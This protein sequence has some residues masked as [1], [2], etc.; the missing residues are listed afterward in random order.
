MRKLINQIVG[1]ENL[2]PNTD[3]LMFF[4][5]RCNPKLNGYW[6]VQRAKRIVAFEPV[7]YPLLLSMIGDEK[8]WQEFQ[9]MLEEFSMNKE[10]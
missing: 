5:A 1:P 9:A 10:E 8:T 6:L 2:T 7:K 3:V 4:M